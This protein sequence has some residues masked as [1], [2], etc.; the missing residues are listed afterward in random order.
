LRRGRR[1][2]HR[3]LSHT[4]MNASFAT[5]A[6]QGAHAVATMMQPNKVASMASRTA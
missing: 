4:N 2:G 1:H 6:S 3:I 5:M